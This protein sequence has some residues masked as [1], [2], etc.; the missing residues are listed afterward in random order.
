MIMKLTQTESDQF[1]KKELKLLKMKTRRI[2]KLSRDR[3]VLKSQKK[4][5]RQQNKRRPGILHPIRRKS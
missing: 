1:S 2:G 3:A 4:T 5:I